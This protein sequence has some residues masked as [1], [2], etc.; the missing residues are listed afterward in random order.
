MLRP[1]AKNKGNKSITY[2]EKIKDI[3]IKPFDR[4]ATKQVLYNVIM[5]AVKGGIHFALVK[6]SKITK[7]TV[8]CGQ[9]LT[10]RIHTENIMI[11]QGIRPVVTRAKWI[12]PLLLNI[13]NETV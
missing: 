3:G 10:I 12:P 13:L 1:Y 8:G 2:D 4:E 11:I 6:E 7:K 9:N 5:N